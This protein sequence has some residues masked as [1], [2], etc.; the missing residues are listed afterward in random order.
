[1]H[2]HEFLNNVC[3]VLLSWFEPLMAAERQHN[4]FAA[5][6]QHTGTPSAPTACVQLFS[7]STLVWNSSLNFSSHYFW[8]CHF[9]WKDLFPLFL[10]CS[11]LASSPLD[12]FLAK[13]IAIFYDFVYC[14]KTVKCF[15]SKMILCCYA[16]AVAPP[17]L[18]LFERLVL[19]FWFSVLIKKTRHSKL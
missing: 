7:L 4:E 5:H 9:V 14:F 6:P 10:L 15:W 12:A 19:Y 2:K 16:H 13:P 18:L 3:Q 11:F 8:T 1:M 17:P